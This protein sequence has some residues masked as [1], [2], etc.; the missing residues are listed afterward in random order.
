MQN[1]YYDQAG[2]AQAPYPPQPG[3]GQPVTYARTEVVVT[4]IKMPF[5]S[6]VAFMIKWTIATIPAMILLF[7]IGVG[8]V[9]LSSMFLA[10]VG[11]ALQ[12]LTR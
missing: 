10:G 5:W 1:Q 2:A 6:M 7:F 8:L 11:A 9:F 4:N 12:G 3:Y